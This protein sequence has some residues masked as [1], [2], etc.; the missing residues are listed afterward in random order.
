MEMLTLFRG[1]SVPK[2]KAEEIKEK[3]ITKGIMGNEGFWQLSLN[4]LRWKISKLFK[5]PDLNTKD[6]RTPDDFPVI[7]AADELGAYYYA[8]VHNRHKDKNEIGLIISFKAPINNIYV[9]GRDFLYTC[10]QLWDKYTTKNYAKQL[11]LLM[12]IYGN[13]I[14]KYFEKASKSEIIDYRIAMCDLATQDINVVKSHHKNTIVIGGR[15]RTIFKSAFLVKA[16]I[17][18]ND[19]LN[20]DIVETSPYSFIPEITLHEFL[21][22][23]I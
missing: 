23:K 2:N 19:I 21:K 10:F 8:L 5:K 1:I 18:P 17:P 20:V 22:G 4:D 13:A 11:N 6:T 12:K 3:I 14:K 7:C 9:D 16:P 15:C